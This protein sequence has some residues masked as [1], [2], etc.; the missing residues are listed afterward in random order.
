[1]KTRFKINVILAK[2][3][4]DSP[5]HNYGG[6]IEVEKGPRVILSADEFSGGSPGASEFREQSGRS[7]DRVA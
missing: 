3:T 2:F 4:Y 5:M 7:R 1:M 6:R